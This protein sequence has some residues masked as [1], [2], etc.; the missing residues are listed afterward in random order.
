MTMHAYDPNTPEAEAGRMRVQGEPRL[1]RRLYLRNK[2]TGF[3]EESLPGQ[4]GK[5][6]GLL[7]SEWLPWASVYV[8]A[9]G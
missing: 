7:R 5:L 4:L 2:R 9:A 8:M 3:P 6:W 1:H